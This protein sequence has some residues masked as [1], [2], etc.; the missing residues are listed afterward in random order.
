[1]T[2]RWKTRLNFNNPNL[3]DSR[4]NWCKYEG[5]RPIYI[6]KEPLGVLKL[7]NEELTLFFEKMDYIN[8]ISLHIIQDKIYKSVRNIASSLSKPYD[9]HLRKKFITP[10]TINT[11]EKLKGNTLNYFSEYPIHDIFEASINRY[12]RIKDG[13]S[14][15]SFIDKVYKKFTPSRYEAGQIDV[16]FH[17][18]DLE[19]ENNINIIR[20]MYKTYETG[21]LG[22]DNYHDHS[23]ENNPYNMNIIIEDIFSSLVYTIPEKISIMRLFKDDNVLIDHVWSYTENDESLCVDIK[24]QF[25]EYIRKIILIAILDVLA[26]NYYTDLNIRPDKH[27]EFIINDYHGFWIRNS[28]SV[29]SYKLKISK[30]INDND[31]ILSLPKSL[32]KNREYF[33]DIFINKNTDKQAEFL[34]SLYDLSNEMSVLDSMLFEESFSGATL[35]NNIKLLTETVKIDLTNVNRELEKLND[36]DISILSE[37][38]FKPESKLFTEPLESIEENIEEHVKGVTEV[39]DLQQLKPVLVLIVKILITVNSINKYSDSILV[40]LNDQ[41]KAYYNKNL[42]IDF[43]FYIRSYKTLI[44]PQNIIPLLF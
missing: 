19:D 42:V 15:Y 30:L 13:N 4:M 16:L 24:D 31:I 38:V 9:S 10:M 18:I 32:S 39:E 2:R 22:E 40:G 34:K 28:E 21:G 29:N 41:F 44:T 5:T 7:T 37:I 11:C 35:Y 43:M 36:D 26:H 25:S 20:D 14:I 8:F 12:I 23:F 27:E 17:T 33:E 3:Y 1:M 6:I